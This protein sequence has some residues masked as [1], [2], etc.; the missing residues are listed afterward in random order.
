MSDPV[1]VPEPAS[2]TLMCLGAVGLL[3]YRWR[4]ALRRTH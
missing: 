1:A 3:G 4:R 2:L